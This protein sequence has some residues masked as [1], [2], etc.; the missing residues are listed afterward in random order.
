MI[1]YRK[2]KQAAVT[3]IALLTIGSCGV[4]N[5]NPP[6]PP[7]EVPVI[8]EEHNALGGKKPISDWFAL[9]PHPEDFDVDKNGVINILESYTH[10]K[11]SRLCFENSAFMKDAD[12]DQ[13]G[14]V[15]QFEWASA[16]ALKRIRKEWEAVFDVNKDGE[17]SV[18]EELAGLDH[19]HNVR[20]YYDNV[21]TATAMFWL[22]TFDAEKAM[23]YDK[24]KNSRIDDEEIG[25]FLTDHKDDLMISYDWN[26]DG[27]IVGIEQETASQVIMQAFE[28]INDYLLALKVDK[29]RDFL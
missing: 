28:E 5:T 18:I 11:A 14:F 12:T 4:V 2:T 21:V 22:N 25:R 29:Y 19:M 17:M 10:I 6:I 13:N 24:N 20:E 23:T 8:E 1:D 15:D 26:A 16:I 9:Q 27:E 7:V 3:L